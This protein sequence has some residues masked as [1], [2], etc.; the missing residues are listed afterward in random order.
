[1]QTVR[2]STLDD[3]ATSIPRIS[4]KGICCGCGGETF[5]VVIYNDGTHSIA[6]PK[7]ECGQIWSPIGEGQGEIAHISRAVEVIGDV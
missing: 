7:F 5:E 3:R 1:M 2:S 4:G 6:C